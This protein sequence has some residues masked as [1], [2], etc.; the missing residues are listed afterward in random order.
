MTVSHRVNITLQ[1][2]I[3][4]IYI[5]FIRRVLHTTS[6]VN[7]NNDYDGTNDAN[8]DHY[9]NPRSIVMVVTTYIIT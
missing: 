4:H 9:D 1:Y 3:F 5:C 6:V 2:A 7:T 8:N